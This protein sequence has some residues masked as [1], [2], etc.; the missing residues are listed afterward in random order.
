MVVQGGGLVQHIDRVFFS[1]MIL[2]RLAAYTPKRRKLTSTGFTLRKGPL[3]AFVCAMLS[4]AGWEYSLKFCGG[5]RYDPTPCGLCIRC[6]WFRIYHILLSV[7]ERQFSNMPDPLS[8]SYATARLESL[9]GQGQ[10]ECT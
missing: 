8:E 9:N 3:N 7:L 5:V 1:L 6:A 2:S 10:R 4:I